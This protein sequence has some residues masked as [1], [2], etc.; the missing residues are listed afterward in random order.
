MIP[1]FLAVAIGFAAL[2]GMN[3]Q[4]NKVTPAECVKPIY[5]YPNK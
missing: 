3:C 4:Y 2:G 5:E 1:L